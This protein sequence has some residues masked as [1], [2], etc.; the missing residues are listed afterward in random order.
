M[1]ETI[2]NIIKNKDIPLS[3]IEASTLR[4]SGS[5]GCE[6]ND[7]KSDFNVKEYNGFVKGWW[8]CPTGFML[9]KRNVFEK[10]I[11]K[12]GDQIKYINDL[13]TTTE[14]GLSVK[15]DIKEQYAFF[16]AEIDPKTKRYLSEDYLF[17]K[18]WVEDCN[19]EIY[20]DTKSQL[21]H[22]G[23]WSFRGD[24]QTYLKNNRF[25]VNLVDDL[26]GQLV[27]DS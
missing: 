22:T 11:E 3:E 19:G 9:I 21:T 7:D 6:R 5:M 1:I 24:L 14:D 23:T 13:P 17:C 27:Q 16:N 18:R 25:R 2:Q 12:I 20:I 15:I 26:H 8:D 10:M 4:Y